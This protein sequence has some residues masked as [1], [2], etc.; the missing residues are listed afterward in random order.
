MRTETLNALEAGISRQRTKGGA[1]PRTLYDLVNGY[2]TLE[3]TIESRPG[4][5]QHAEL[6]AGTKGLIAF[7]SGMVVFASSLV[8]GMPSGYR[9]EVLLHPTDPDATLSIVWFAGAFLGFLYVVGQFSDGLIRHYWL[10]GATAWQAEHVY[11]LGEL[12]EPTVRN[13]Y[14]YKAHRLG[15]PGV[16]WAPD[17][18][19][20]VGDVVEPTEPNGF[21]YTVIDTLGANPRS[22]ATEPDWPTEDG[23]T[24]A[25][26]T[27]ITPSTAASTG[28]STSSTALPEETRERYGRG[29]DD[30][31]AGIVNRALDQ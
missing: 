25:E 17:V 21:K 14:T 27:D 1:N 19:R 26:D 13:G 5:V 20:T 18:A 4:T 30:G 11:T 24:I 2:V 3:G 23:A 12:V 29:L 15:A 7:D 8:G 10:Q 16:L 6:P 22:G 31:F 9:C 28:T